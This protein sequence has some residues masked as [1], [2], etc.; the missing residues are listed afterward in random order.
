MNQFLIERGVLDIHN[1]D[2]VGCVVDSGGSYFSAISFPDTIHAG[3]R[4]ANAPLYFEIAPSQLLTS[5]NASP[6]ADNST[7][8]AC[9]SGDN[10]CSIRFSNPWK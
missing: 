2:I 1:S 8:C 10:S 9:T 3:I 6:D 4:V 7:I 5:A